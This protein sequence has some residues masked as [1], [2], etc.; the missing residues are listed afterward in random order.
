MNPLILRGIRER[1]R[2]KHLIAAGLFSLILCSTIYLSS[3]LEGAEGE[4]VHDPE[5][6]DSETQGWHRTE[7]SPIKGARQAFTY[8][9]ALQG[10]FLMFL[11]TGRVAAI[12]AEEK[13][14][15]LMDYQRMT[16]MNPFSKILGYLFGLPAREYYMFVITLP[17]LLHCMIVGELSPENVLHLYFVFFSSVVLYHLTAHVIGLVVPKPRA[18]SWVSRIVVLGLYIFLPLFGQAGISFLSFLTILPT[19]FGKMLPQLISLEDSDYGY[20]RWENE[21]IDFWQDVP[22]FTTEIS[23]SLFTLIMQGLILA[24]L[25]I[26]A[27]RKWRNESLPAFSKT[28]G[29]IIFTVFQ[30]LLLGSLWPFFAEGK[31]SGLLGETFS[32]ENNSMHAEEGI[33]GLIFVQSVFFGLSILGI[34]TLIN[35]CCPDRHLHLK[36]VQRANRLGLSSIPLSADESRGTWFAL[37]LSG[38]VCAVHAILLDQAQKSGLFFNF[39]VYG[40]Q[41]NMQID[42]GAYLFPSLLVIACAIYLQAARELWFSL[43]F[44]GFVGLLWVTPLLACLV[45]AV[46]TAGEQLELITALSSFCPILSLPQILA[47]QYSIPAPDKIGQALS[48]GMW[49][50]LVVGCFLAAYLSFRLYRRSKQ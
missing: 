20:H 24:A 2:G 22:F 38:M 21:M 47:S 36:G 11:G 13:E 34:L 44:W 39:R 12:T 7:S 14:S 48:K 37:V 16:P 3:Y 30:F 33:L 40:L 9:L 26:T 49:T 8:L 27:Y 15:G 42:Y 1:L 32:L 6:I 46:G 18:A 4:W 45:I 31:A 43:G 29:I 17:F 10:F 19:Y 50:G 23:P 28:S 35:T 5:K 41:R 25:L